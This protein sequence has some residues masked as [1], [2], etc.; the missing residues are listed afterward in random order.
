MLASN[1]LFCEEANYEELTQELDIK[2]V[3][4][5]TKIPITN[6]Q[7]RRPFSI[8]VDTMYYSDNDRVYKYV[9]ILLKAELEAGKTRY[10]LLRRIDLEKE[11]P[12]NSNINHFINIINF[13]NR[14]ILK[15]AGKYEV[16]SY[17]LKEKLGGES[18]KE[19]VQKLL[20]VIAD[21]KAKVIGKQMLV[22][23]SI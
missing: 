1:I 11:L 7:E 10:K 17:A 15:E 20:E 16:N 19:Q 21:E 6:E 9:Y 5:L 23:E 22:V 3:F 4:T 14:E 13:E 2:G 18:S 12:K 8:F